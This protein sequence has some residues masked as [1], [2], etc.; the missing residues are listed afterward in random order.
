MYA[1]IL[2]LTSVLSLKY[3]SVHLCLFSLI[4]IF[5]N[6]ITL[7]VQSC[8]FAFD[9]LQ[10][11]E[12]KQSC[13]QPSI[14]FPDPTSSLVSCEY[15]DPVHMHAPSGLVSIFIISCNSR[16][17]DKQR[18]KMEM[19]I[20]QRNTNTMLT[21]FAVRLPHQL[22]QCTTPNLQK[23]GLLYSL[24]LYT[25]VYTHTHSL[26]SLLGCFYV[27]LGLTTWAWIIYQGSLFPKK[28]N[29]LSQQPFIWGLGLVKLAMSIMA[30]QL[31]VSLSWSYLGNL[32]DISWVQSPCHV[33]KMLFLI[34]CPDP[35]ALNNGSIPSST[36]FPELWGQGLVIC[37]KQSF[38]LE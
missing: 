17:Y 28:T 27:Y 12:F 30:Y 8:P 31:A 2:I 9:A 22:L 3:V 4:L 6:E 7:N 26:V 1:S 37:Y 5:I 16:H 11:S 20:H 33:Y 19:R 18:E 14:I 13:L 38:T 35:P 34:R 25:F 36:V 29:S 24:L 15:H 21:A 10:I 32:V 23:H